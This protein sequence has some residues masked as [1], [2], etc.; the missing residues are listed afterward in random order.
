[1]PSRSFGS[2]SAAIPHLTRGKGGVAGEVSDL[3]GDVEVAF[4]ALETEVDAS[5]TT[6]RSDGALRVDEWTAPPAAD[7]VAFL[8]E[9]AT[10]ATATTYAAADL[11]ASTIATGPRGI[12]V[13][14]AA[15]VGSYTTDDIV[16]VGTAYGEPVTL[17]FTPLDA[18]GGDTIA[19]TEALGLDTITSVTI[20]AQV[21]AAGAIS[22]GFTSDMILYRPIRDLAGVAAPLQEIEGGV[23]VTTGGFTGRKYLPPV[24]VPDGALDFAVA[25]IAD[26]S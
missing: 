15:A 6:L 10:A 24:N 3:R 2:Q 13:T 14:R 19:S 22:L 23:A 26:F 8:D 7:A 25:Y 9:E 5:F 21:D 20:P 4:T 18:D 12:L 16:V 1:M 17:T 11:L